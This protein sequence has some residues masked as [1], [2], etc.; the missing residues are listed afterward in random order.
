[1]NRAATHRFT[2]G[3]GLEGSPP[4]RRRRASR[5][6]RFLRSVRRAPCFLRLGCVLAVLF[7][8]AGFAP[9]GSPAET[10]HPAADGPQRASG[11]GA[12]GPVPDVKMEALKDALSFARGGPPDSGGWP[13]TVTYDCKVYDYRSGRFRQ[14]PRSFT[15][16]RKPLKIVPHAVGVAEILW[17]ICPRERIVGFMEFAAD[18]DFSVLAAEIG[19]QGPVVR[20][21]QTELVIGMNP[22]LVFTVFYSDA[23]FRARLKQAGIPQFELGFF[24]TLESIKEQILLVGTVIGE[25]GNALA[26][27]ERVDE[28][29]RELQAR[30]PP[31]RE[32]VRVLFYDSRGYVP[33]LRT[34][35][36]SIC[37]LI[38][39]VNV[40]A[41]QGVDSW[42]RIDY[43]TFLKWDPDIVL[44]P[45]NRRLEEELR[46][47]PISARARAVKTARI[48]GIPHL[49]ISVN[50][51]FMVLSAHLIAGIVYASER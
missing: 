35:F 31:D 3:W 25:K 8:S 22:D 40:A 39:A 43:E 42:S 45:E 5:A 36:H 1:M 46:R 34:N 20:Q 11:E 6:P 15:V 16:E 28:K 44:V 49:H 47:N 13:R 4:G 48:H 33:G 37:E 18:P 14:E 23:A 19:R 30:I 51:Q 2:D 41:E 29:V 7:G 27:V 10:A 17:A 12:R 24:G 50:S 32:R 38:G 9:A 26:L 21:T